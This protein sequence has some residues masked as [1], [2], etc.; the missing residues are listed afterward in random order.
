VPI[1]TSQPQSPGWW[2]ARLYGRLAD[3]ERLKRLNALDAWYRG[4]P[5]LLGMNQVQREA[6]ESFRPFARTNFAKLIVEALRE[7]LTPVG[8][9]T[10][11]D[12]DVTGDREAWR[13][14]Q[15]SG[16]PVTQAEVHR[17]MF[18]FGSTYVIVGPPDPLS[19]VPVVT[20]E[21]PRQI[22][23]E[24]DPAQPRKV[25][26]ALKIYHDDVEGADFAYLWLPGKLWVARRDYP[27]D[28][29]RPFRSPAGPDVVFAPNL[30]DW[31]TERTVTLP[32]PAMLPVH[33]FDN[34]D[35]V[36]EFEPHLDL[37]RRINHEI[38][39]R[40]TISA[41]Q[42]MKQR[43]IKNLPDVDEQG[44]PVDYSDV[45][46]VDPGV[47]WQVP[48]GVE[49]WES[50]AV[51]LGPVLAACKSDIEN[52]AS[53]TRTPMHYLTPAGVNQ[54]AEGAALAREGLVFKVEDRQARCEP[55]WS[56]VIADCF[57]WLGDIQRADLDMITIIWASAERYS[58]AE[59]YAAAVQAQS[60]GVPWRTIMIDVLGFSPDRVDQMQ[61]ERADDQ[62]FQ[63]HLLA[64]TTAITTPP[65]QAAQSA[66][67]A[68]SS[69][70]SAVKGQAAVNAAKAGTKVPVGNMPA[71]L[72]LN[73]QRAQAG[74]PLIGQT[75]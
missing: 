41:Y 59:R 11:A 68:G 42:A 19:K 70:D 45:F 21:D 47:I 1:D 18:R 9:R 61:A 30:F 56:D 54:S 57:L 13:I 58:M 36:A 29:Y 75:T 38:L 15:R 50:G 6:T 14:W 12:D 10:S 32:D 46:A 67:S 69:P 3:P 7:R 27:N 24:H 62:L 74:Q 28:A 37:L 17:A 4:E 49:F 34:E 55:Q 66:G 44:N 22:I 40:M 52:L 2:L 64:Q 63:A 65:E 53:V 31:D 48:D 43:A 8:I 39:Q 25:L 35:G 5:P 23:T 71:K 33:R 26:A 73:A 51:D 60:A 16:L 72:Q 20:S